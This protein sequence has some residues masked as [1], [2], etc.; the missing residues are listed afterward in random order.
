MAWFTINGDELQLINME[1]IK[2]ILQ[3]VAGLGLLNVWLLRFKQNTRY[4]GKSATSMKEEFA[5]YGLSESF[6]WLVGFL[7]LSSAAGLLLGLVVPSLVVPAAS[8]LVVLMLGA[9]AMHLKVKDPLSKSVP[10]VVMLLMAI[11]I[12]IL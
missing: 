3:V 10:A 6:M 8:L 2:D 5:A 1:W 9:V 7:K 11:L 12:L 4:R